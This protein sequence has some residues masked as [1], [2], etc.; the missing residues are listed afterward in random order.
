ALAL[1]TLL[2]ISRSAEPRAARSVHLGFVDAQGDAFY[3]ETVVEKSTDGSYFMVCGWD[4]GYFGIQQLRADRKVAIF[5]VWD[6]TKGDDPTAVKTED[7]VE[8]LYQSP[9]ARIKRFGGEGTGGQCMIDFNWRLGETNQFLIHAKTETNNIRKTAYTAYVKSPTD[10]DWRKLATF[11]VQTKN[12][13]MRGLYSFV[14]DFR[15]DTKSVMDERRARFGNAWL[16]K[17][18]KWTPLT[19]A[20]FTASNADWESKENIDAGLSENW[21]YLATGGDIKKSRE[22]RSIIELPTGPQTP[23]AWRP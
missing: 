14:E 22:L 20:R 17:S 15:R 21:F 9:D 6:P 18:D 11:R 16:L 4:T 19:R 12:E 23:P 13:A 8:L 2:R 5:S 7:R 10:T 1:F 3:N